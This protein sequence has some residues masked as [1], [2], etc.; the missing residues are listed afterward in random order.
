MIAL[1]GRLI[2]SLI[3]GWGEEVVTILSFYSA[4]PFM[5]WKQM[6]CTKFGENQD[7]KYGESK[8]G[9]VS[10]PP[11]LQSQLCRNAWNAG[12]QLHWNQLQWSAH[13]LTHPPTQH[14]PTHAGNFPPNASS[15]KQLNRSHEYFLIRNVRT[16]RVRR[17][18]NLFEFYTGWFLMYTGIRQ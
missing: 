14:P 18:F 12:F 11:P 15:P 9:S 7:K 3:D 2:L 5:I 17:I 8:G 16:V 10:T 1:H 6:K 4:P 13:P